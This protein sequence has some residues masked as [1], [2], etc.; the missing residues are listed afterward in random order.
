M[1]VIL[2]FSNLPPPG[3]LLLFMPPPVLCSQVRT[4]NT[5]EK[6]EWGEGGGTER[7]VSIRLRRPGVTPFVWQQHVPAERPTS[8]SLQ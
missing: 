3:F 7:K 6:T 1:F 5:G 8:A 4:V 2:L